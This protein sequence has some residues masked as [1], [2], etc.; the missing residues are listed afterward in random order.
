[1]VSLRTHGWMNATATLDKGADAN[2]HAE[3]EPSWNGDC[4]MIGATICYGYRAKYYIWLDLSTAEIK[5][6]DDIQASY[7]Q[8]AKDQQEED[9]R[10]AKIQGTARYQ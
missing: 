3:E 1:M 5:R 7:I 4:F 2:E 8:G 10:Q 9:K 6:K